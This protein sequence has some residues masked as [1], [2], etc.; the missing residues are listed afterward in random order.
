M[1]FQFEYV[2]PEE[3]IQGSTADNESEFTGGLGMVQNREADF[4]LGDVSLS[5]ERRQAVEFTFFT[6]ADSGAFVTH[7]PRVL[8][9]A[10]VI[11]RPFKIDVWPYVI[12]TVIVSGPVLYFIIIIPKMFHRIPKDMKIYPEYISEITGYGRNN[13]LLKIQEEEPMPKDLFDKCIWFTLQLFLKQCESNLLFEN[14]YSNQNFYI[15]ACSEPYHGY[16]A[17]FLVIVYW[18]AAT[19]VLAYVYSAQLTSQFAKPA[20]EAAIKTLHK[21][22][23]AMK[24]DKYNLYVENGSLSLVMLENNKTEIFKRLFNLMKNQP[25]NMEQ[26]YLINSTKAGLDLI[27][28]GTDKEAVIGGRETLLYNIRKYGEYVYQFGIAHAFKL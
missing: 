15:I 2:L 4:F 20:K 16:R 3:Q 17:R 8:S 24:F 12:F 19:Y 18:I 6:L 1:N 7:A 27:V 11:L 5:S 13:K 21:L 14:I 23:Y 22:E 10:F 9:E 25:G 26:K 28:R